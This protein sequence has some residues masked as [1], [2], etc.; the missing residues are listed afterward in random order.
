MGINQ[1]IPSLHKAVFLDRDGVINQAIVKNGKPYPPS[2][3]SELKIIAGVQEAFQDL[4]AAGFLLIVVTNQPDVA[5]GTTDKSVVEKI[6]NALMS[7]LPLNDVFVCYHDNK[8]QCDCRKPLPGLILQAAAKYDINL[9]SSFMV[10]D[11]WRDV[12]AGK[13]AGCKTIWI[14]AG[15]DEPRPKSIPDFEASS[16]KE[17]ATLIL[18]N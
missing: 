14:N 4:R 17:A 7:K 13:N 1:V 18:M 3:L 15:Y 10:G 11:R 9:T 12:E 6:N 5:R 16:L 2:Q 8:D